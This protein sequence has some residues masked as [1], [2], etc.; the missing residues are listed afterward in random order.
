MARRSIE[1]RIRADLRIAARRGLPGR[2]VTELHGAAG[3]I[4]RR[5]GEIAA[6]ADR[7]LAA[8]ELVQAGTDRRMA[9]KPR[10]IYALAEPPE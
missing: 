8:G 1:D 3:L 10:I 2:T 6:A 9:W 5:I 4:S 7:L